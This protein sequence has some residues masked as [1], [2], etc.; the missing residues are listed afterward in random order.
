MNDRPDTIKTFASPNLGWYVLLDG[1]MVLLATLVS[2]PRA[3]ERCKPVLPLPSRKAL[4]WILAAATAV[5]VGEGAYAY[6]AAKR[7]GFGKSAPC[8][9]AQTFVVGFPSLLKMASLARVDSVEA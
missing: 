4:G 1:G 5:H 3:Y 8:W 7:R 9:A 6:K 2:N